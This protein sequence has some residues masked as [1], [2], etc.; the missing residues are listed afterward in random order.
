MAS[1]L[2]DL[3]IDGE[4]VAA[5]EAHVP[6]SDVGFSRGYGVFEAMRSYDGTLFRLGPHL[7]RLERSAAAMG[8]DLPPR[9]DLE[10]WCVDRGA[11]GDGVVRVLVSAHDDPFD[12]STKRVVVFAEAMP[13]IPPTTTVCSLFAPWHP[14]GALSELTGVKTLAY[15]PNYAA[16]RTA[17]QRGYDDALLIG[18]SGNVLEGPTNSVAWTIDGRVETPALD[19]GILRSVTRDAMV[20]LCTDS[21]IELVE[22]H[23]PL[24]RVLAA[25]EVMIMSTGHEI[26][27]IVKVDDITFPEGPVT[28][29]LA[30]AFT[31]LRIREMH[32]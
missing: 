22:V 5:A 2:G 3:I 29:Q 32:R 23:Q 6:I 27:P 16:R 24:D 14:D 17:H 7:D 28:A 20:E 26:A 4:A 13:E 19:L 10:A 9:A 8:I 1:Y 15:A 31:A 12:S 30:E 25:H 11:L 21:G 18:R